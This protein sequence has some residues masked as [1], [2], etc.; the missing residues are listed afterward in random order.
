MKVTTTAVLGTLVVGLWAGS[1]AA[2]QPGQQTGGPQRGVRGPTPEAVA[3]IVTDSNADQLREQVQRLTEQYPPAVLEMLR[4]DPTLALNDTY[5][6]AYP[7]L[8]AL[9]GQHPE[10][11]QNGR[12]FFGLPQ[13]N[14]YARGAQSNDPGAQRM[15]EAREMFGGFL[16]FI[17]LMTL[18]FALTWLIK[19]AVDHRRWLRASKLQGDMQSRLL[20]R[21][22]SNEELVGFVQSAAGQRAL[23]ALTQPAV[24]NGR[25]TWTMPLNRILW[26]IQLGTVA[27]L[28]GFG[29]MLLAETGAIRASWASD[30][31]PLF[32]T[33]G[34]VSLSIGA[35][36]LISAAASFF[37]SRRLGLLAAPAPADA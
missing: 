7:G 32:F 23:E 17:G 19:M 36:F 13:Y 16:I 2:A 18:L 29:L 10:I 14:G 8:R 35:G 6:A 34:M 20:D 9:V 31:S 25:T 5:M 12:Y 1:A 11:V 4:I 33:V 21:L 27:A 28:L 26:S 37:I 15:R 22:T 30:A 24:S 3:S